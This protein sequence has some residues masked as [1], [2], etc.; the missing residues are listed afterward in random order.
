MATNDTSTPKGRENVPQTVCY[1]RKKVTFADAGASGGVPIE[2]LRKGSIIVGTDIVVGTAFNAATTNVLTVGTNAT[3]YDNIVTSAQAVP[4]TTGIKQNLAPTGTA[5]GPLAN[6]SLVY[7]K[8]TQ[9]GTA[10]TAGEAYII[11]K[12]VNDR[13]R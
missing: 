8:Y 7:V 1:I 6:D 4:G 9:S 10:A 2:W 11:I 5:L 12:F 13:D 3:A